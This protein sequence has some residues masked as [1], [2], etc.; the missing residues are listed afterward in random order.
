M[1]HAQLAW[2]TVSYEWDSRVA[3]FD[4]E[5]QQSLFLGL[6]WPDTSPARL[7]AALAA[8]AACLLGAQMLW[9]RWRTRIP[10]DP[11]KKRYEHFCR[12]LA[13]LGVKRGNSSGGGAR[14]G[15]VGNWSGGNCSAATKLRKVSP[16]WRC[17]L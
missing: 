10:R 4:D 5:N 3:N 14:N 8:A 1:H 7:I 2:D 11:L 17:G 6:G 16:V 13:A 12:R 15:K 9:T